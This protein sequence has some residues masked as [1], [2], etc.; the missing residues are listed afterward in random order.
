MIRHGINRLILLWC[1]VVPSSVTRLHQSS[2][3]ADVH[4]T[5]SEVKRLSRHL[6][7]VKI[8]ITVQ[9]KTAYF[10]ETPGRPRRIYTLNLARLQ[11][12]RHW[13]VF[14]NG[15]DMPPPYD[16]AIQIGAGGSYDEE[17][18][19]ADPEILSPWGPP[20][21]LKP[22]PIPLRGKFRFQVTYFEGRK[23]W[24]TYVAARRQGEIVPLQNGISKPPVELAKAVSEEFEFPP[25][26]NK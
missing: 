3:D 18:D 16:E 15:Y 23:N 13:F 5:V 26:D 22:Q 1:L 9:N 4:L 8:K 6:V 25:P 17:F 21:R 14:P 11:S 7:H 24:D 20:F 12:G 10:P 19:V 2:P